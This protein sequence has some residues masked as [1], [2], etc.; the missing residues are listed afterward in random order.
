MTITTQRQRRR[1]QIFLDHV[2]SYAAIEA[3]LA[4][5]DSLDFWLKHIMH[6]LVRAI[7]KVRRVLN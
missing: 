5:H 1:P 7:R 6:D 4:E 2:H 3:A